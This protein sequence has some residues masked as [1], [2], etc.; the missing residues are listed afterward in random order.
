MMTVLTD[1]ETDGFLTC[2]NGDVIDPWADDVN[3]IGILAFEAMHGPITFTVDASVCDGDSGTYRNDITAWGTVQEDLDVHD[4][5]FA[6]CEIEIVDLAG[7][8]PGYWKQPH[9]FGNYPNPFFPGSSI[10]S[11]GFAPMHEHDANDTFVDAL[12]YKG[13]KGLK[14][15]EGILLRAAAAGWIN[16]QVLDYG[17]VPVL[18]DLVADV[19]FAIE[20]ND[21][22]T[23]LALAGIIDGHNNP[24]EDFDEEEGPWCPLGRAPGD[25]LPG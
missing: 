23:M 19:N 22:Q 7:C 20:S 16:T 18:A 3:N 17:Y 11:E 21:R 6:E 13:G 15:A 25:F 12:K 5:A 2:P 8:T 14:G 10:G 24:P 9:H 1:V 4:E